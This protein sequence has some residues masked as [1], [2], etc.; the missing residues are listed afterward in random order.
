M[1]S[2][3]DRPS[4]WMMAMQFV[5]GQS[6]SYYIVVDGSLFSANGLMSCCIGWSEVITEMLQ[7]DETMF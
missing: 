3:E 4:N 5:G 7:V 2:S 6:M 1:T